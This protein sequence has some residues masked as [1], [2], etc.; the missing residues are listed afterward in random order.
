MST[1]K[2]S[3]FKSIAKSITAG[4]W[5]FL[6]SKSVSATEI[7]A[8]GRV[9]MVEGEVF[10]IRNGEKIAL[11]KD[12]PILQ[13]DTILTGTDGSVGVTFI[14]DTVFSLGADGEMTIDEMVY[15]ADKQEGK[16]AANM[17]T[18]VFSFISGEIAKIDPDGM[19]I[20]TP[21]GTIGIR[22]T[23]VA[24]V[25]A[26]EG[27]EN[28]VS[29]L[30]ETGRDGQTIIGEVVLTNAS[31]SVVLNQ[32]G[33]TVQLSS[34]NQVPPTPVVLST[35]QIQQSYGKTLTTLSSTVLAKATNDAVAA[36]QEVVEKEQVAEEAKV[37]AEEAQKVAEETGDK[38]AIA[39]AEK[40]AEVAEEAIAEVEVAKEVVEEIKEVV[41]IAKQEFEV[42]KEAFKE[43]V[44]DEKPE[45]Q[46][47]EQEKPEDAEKGDDAE[48][49]P[50]EEGREPEE[51]A[52]Q[53]VVAPEGPIEG[54]GEEQLEGEPEVL[55][56]D[57]EPEVIEGEK[58]PEKPLL[59]EEAPP[60][61]VKPQEQEVVEDAPA[62]V[63][64][65]EKPPEQV[66]EAAPEQIAKAA[67]EPVL[68]Q[69]KPQVMEAPQKPIYIAPIVVA[70][71]PIM[72]QEVVEEVKFIPRAA[73]LKVQEVSEIAETVSEETVEEETVEEIRPN[74]LN[75]GGTGDTIDST[76]NIGYYSM[77]NGQ[78]VNKQIAPI[79]EAGHN[80]V[81]MTTLSE[82]E[83]ASVDILWAINPSNSSY[84]NEFTNAVDRIKERVDDGM[85]LVIHD[86]QVG[87]A[88]NILFG[89]E[90]AEIIRGFS[91]G[92]KIDVIDETTVIG[93][94]PG[95]F[96]TDNSIDN[97]NY[98]NHGYTKK[99]T[100]P[101]DSL[102][103]LNTSNEDQIVDFAYKYGE[104]AVVYSSIPLDF[105]LGG[106]LPNF[107]DIY[108]PNVLQF[109][110][111]LITDGYSTIQGT[112]SS[113]II[114]GTANDDVLEGRDGNDT[115]FGLFGDDILNGGAGADI[116]NGGSGRDVYIFKSLSDS[117]AGFGDTIKD[118]ND[119]NDKIDI[120][121]ITTTFNLVSSF[122]GN[123]STHEVVYN[124]S[125]KLLQMDADGDRAA[126]M[127]LTLE[128]YT[129][130]FE[131]GAYSS[132]VSDVW[133]LEIG[134]Y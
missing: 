115:L 5:M 99:D 17:V 25:A 2:H 21:V 33:A 78:G 97:G 118:F 65:E 60:E 67:P 29:L 107:K 59:L 44:A 16:F 18:G 134:V 127:E 117:P 86:R 75:V 133:S 51:D 76:M 4:L 125:T 35:Q 23:K 66:V 105:Y 100:L 3:E 13:G 77:T 122:T 130:S 93:E 94:G 72:Y 27:T 89:E 84:G 131:E 90:P 40:L 11:G 64:A 58:P 79:E 7:D 95:G 112:N 62:E 120:S 54:E 46:P 32:V 41:E 57:G 26:A 73:P 30:P 71:Q 9:D 128:N 10:V 42:Q 69:P 80:A 124:A 104:G 123:T 103:L 20:N 37:A 83:L 28:S 53:D 68:E 101:D 14:D 22:G 116:L 70:A 119:T 132:S 15:D 55:E 52:P 36:E 91:N 96:L 109:A 34:S 111:S 92:R 114:A 38:E 50:N 61:N 56:G 39:E 8:I 85:V 12:D 19:S 88:E 31:G 81:K 49:Q 121:N 82:T 63:I 45:E 108:A 106:Y 6:A 102:A 1:R 74:L 113:E 48:Q 98:S 24:G 126:D 87:N 129:G 110:A 47:Q 43:F